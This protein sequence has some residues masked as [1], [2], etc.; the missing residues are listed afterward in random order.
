MIFIALGLPDA[1]I[2]SGWNLIRVDMKMPLSAIGITTAL[3]YLMTIISTYN[4]PRLLR[5]IPTKYVIL[6]SI[7]LSSISLFLISRANAYYQMVLLTV[8]LGLSAGAIDLSVNHYVSHFYKASHMNYLHSFY[9]IGVTFG[10]SIMAFT[11][12]KSTWRS[13][14]IIT[15]SLLLA[16]SVL[17]II[18]L[19][20][21]H[22]ETEESRKEQ[23]A[24]ISTKAVL[25]IKGVKQSMAIILT[26]VHIESLFGVLVASYAFMVLNVE[27]SV[28]ALFTTSYFLALTI[29][30][31]VSGILSKKMHSNMMIIYGQIIIMISALILIIFNKSIWVSFFGIL[32]LGFG[33]GPIFPNMMYMNARNF[34]KSYSSKITSL[35]MIVGYMGF[36]LLTPLAGYFFQKTTLDLYPIYALIISVIL[37]VITLWYMNIVKYKFLFKKEI[38]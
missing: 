5:K 17:V 23:H 33:S 35:Q 27:A 38:K 21:W 37:F 19:P 29:G 3:T 36:G 10:P 26:Y 15:G 11:L 20:F 28:A 8:P 9:G 2:G 14:Y 22:E 1:L 30:R 4:A 24:E 16:I 31:I 6:F 32:L 12:L 13:A 18:S 7:F 34:E 25:K